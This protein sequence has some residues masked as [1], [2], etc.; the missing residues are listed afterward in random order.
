MSKKMI[1]KKIVKN[2]M[3]WRN[4]SSDLKE[5]REQLE[6]IEERIQKKDL[7]EVEL[8]LMLEHAYRHLNFAWNTRRVTTK[9]YA[10]LT[11]DEFNK[12]SQFPKEIQIYTLPKKRKKKN[13]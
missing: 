13:S 3:N 7:A 6:E 2:K 5:A 1:N 12:W 4:V 9:N 11:E 8:Q 10:N